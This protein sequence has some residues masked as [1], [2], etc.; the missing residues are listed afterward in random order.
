MSELDQ[1]LE[2]KY[3]IGLDVSTSTV[4]VCVF[5]DL[6]DKG[7]LVELTHFSLNKPKDTSREETLVIKAN[8]L[9][10]FIYEKY[11]DLNIS[12]IIIEEP[13]MN[14]KQP[15]TAAML[16]LFGGMV[17]IRL[18]NLFQINPEYIHIDKARRFG[19]PEL[20]GG[21]KQTLFSPFP[22]EIQGIKIK[23]YRK[24]IILCSVA[25]RYPEVQWLLNRNF[26]VDKKNCDRADSIVV[27]LGLKAMKG[28]W[29]S[30]TEEIHS[31]IDFLQKNITYQKFIKESVDAHKTLLPEEKR[32]LKIDY[33]KDVFKIKNFLNVNL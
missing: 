18:Q 1:N 14:S 3:I 21:K 2:K 24:L 23:D 8:E 29:E 33:L 30:T 31:T 15:N 20:V 4:G 11:K 28:E 17:Y 27:V 12:E 7:A 16:N 5:E 13:L 25:K 6:G 19:L 22:R 10:N 32:N 26:T 9:T